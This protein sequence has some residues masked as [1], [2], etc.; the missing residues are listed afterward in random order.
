MEVHRV[1]SE[2]F[3]AGGQT[4]RHDEAMHLKTVTH[5]VDTL[6]SFIGLLHILRAKFVRREMWS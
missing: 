3:H 5:A 1:G 4:D 2:F 6:L